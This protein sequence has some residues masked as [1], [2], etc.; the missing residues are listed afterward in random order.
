[1]L[2]IVKEDF[3]NWCVAVYNKLLGMPLTY[4]NSFEVWSD[5]QTI[6]S[7]CCEITFIN[8]GDSTLIIN[9]SAIVQAGSSIG[10]DGKKNEKDTTLYRI[11]FTGGTVNSCC[12]I[13]KYYNH[14]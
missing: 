3:V 1:M 12:I 7:F 13:K 9:G 14:L 10:F 11:A 2:N 5:S 4:N 8:Q 6:R